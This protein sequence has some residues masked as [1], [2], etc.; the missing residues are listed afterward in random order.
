MMRQKTGVLAVALA[1]AC[2]GG[3]QSA[4]SWFG[5]AVLTGV[6]GV[7]GGMKKIVSGTGEGLM[8]ARARCAPQGPAAC[9]QWTSNA[10]AEQ[11]K[12]SGRAQRLPNDYLARLASDVNETAFTLAFPPGGAVTLVETG[13]P[14]YKWSRTLI[15]HSPSDPGAKDFVIEN[16]PSR[17]MTLLFRPRLSGG[18][19]ASAVKM[20]HI[21]QALRQLIA[22]RDAATLRGLQP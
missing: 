19:E 12:A 15:I 13:K 20:A 4:E 1:L 21:K 6:N 22:E 3:A 2:P 17:G 5:E 11:L 7:V 9:E 18:L 8:A 16:V 14:F 10:L